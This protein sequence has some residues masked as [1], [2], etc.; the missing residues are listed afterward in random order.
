MK[1][2]VL[3]CLLFTGNLLLAQVQFE[4]KVSRNTV[5]VNERF[6]I[7]FSMNSDG[8]N[9]NPPNF[10]A[11]GF[12]LIAGPSQMVSQSWVN[13]SSSFQKAYSYTLMPKQK[14][15]LTIKSATIEINGQVYKTDP[16]KI[17]VSNAIELP[18]DPNQIPQI[19]VDDNLYLVADISKTNPFVNEPI[20]VVYKLYF[21]NN[22]GISDF[23]E[24]NK[25]KYNDFWSQNID[26]KE[27]N[28]GEET[29]KGQRFRFVV[30]RK[31]VLYP[32]KSG[33]LDIEPLSL[34]IECQVPVGRRNI[35]GQFQVR[36]ASKRVSAGNQSI[37]VKALPESGKPKDFAGAVGKF[38][39]AVVP[40][41]TILKSGESLNLKVSVTGTGN[42]KLFGLPKPVVPSSLEMYDPEHKENI[43]TPL[44]GMNGSIVDNYT[45]IPQ[46]KGN[47]AIKPIK[48]SYFDLGTS[49]YKTITS[50]EINLNVL[51]G[52]V[53]ASKNPTL[54]PNKVA[55][56]ATKSFA[57]IKQKT[58]LS[59][60]DKKGFLGS[61]LFY[62]L[63]F[64][65][66]LAIPF[67]V[68]VKKK[69]D[70]KDADIFGNKIK[71]SKK[72]AKK[73]LSE[74]K[75]HLN[76]KEP[77]YIA[78]E[79][80]LH[81]FLKAK[82]NIETSEMSKDKIAEIMLDRNANPEIISK[83]IALTENC[84]LARYAQ[85]SSVAI[86]QDY[87]KAVEIISELEKQIS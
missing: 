39:F 78:L 4:A 69:K 27:F 45:I 60:T 34:E 15:I 25:P 28:P 67:V 81:N 53:N 50:S 61:G 47:Y 20:T 21:S 11:C 80:S 7:D 18:K 56:E 59:Q 86:Q 75:Q 77:F 36:E 33:K 76:N 82:I 30:L 51:Q 38:N 6:R 12:Q 2:I 83:F 72:L 66:L 32:Q 8:D 37:N 79:K 10:E 29:F 87:D 35:F 65:P 40:S 16:V 22:I 68:I 52:D 74:A 85:S 70:E 41:T 23:K 17:S 13:G 64:L 58:N 42:L 84:E 24:L 55:V 73:Y 46:Y 9:F 44:S 54:N 19:N 43:N 31:T 48:F 14:G 3:I 49:S 63:L 57:Y 62:S 71:M 1:K 26:I 5:G